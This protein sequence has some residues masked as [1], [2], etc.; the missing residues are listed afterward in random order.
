[1]SARIIP[2][3]DPD[4][5]AVGAERLAIRRVFRASCKVVA[6]KAVGEA[7]SEV[8]KTPGTKKIGLDDAWP[9][10]IAAMRRELRKSGL[11]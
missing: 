5:P 9:M 11:F 4:L 10:F 6:A 2:F 8:I 7:F 3:R 1:M